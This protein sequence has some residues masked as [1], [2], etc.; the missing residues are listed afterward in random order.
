[1]GE[2]IH[3]YVAEAQKIRNNINKELTKH[4]LETESDL[5]NIRS[6]ISNVR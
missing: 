5:T 4:K 2:R 1:M 6:D 3:E